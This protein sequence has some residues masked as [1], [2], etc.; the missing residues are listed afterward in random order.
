MKNTKFKDLYLLLIKH[1]KFIVFL[2]VIFVIT[3]IILSFSPKLE[4]FHP[5]KVREFIL[6]YGK[7]A[8][9]VFI[10]LQT[11][12]VIFA[13]IPGQ[14]TGF[15]GGYLFGWK[16]GFLY[17]MIGL[18]VGS[19]IIFILSRKLGRP[20]VQKFNSAEAIHDFEG[21]FIA[22]GSKMDKGISTLKEH[23]LLTFFLIMLL[24]ALP[25]DLVCFVAGLSTIPIYK[26]LT[27][28]LLGRF[29]GML[30]LSLVG[31]G[32]SKDELNIFYVVFI[33]FCII[34]MVF[35]LFNKKSVENYMKR[36]VRKKV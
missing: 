27:A 30:V 28:A 11:L 16:L 5:K 2:L 14:A 8:P 7:F 6:G 18:T 33:V 22:D 4:A 17:S 26:L 32:V 23:S 36:F 24:P 12:Q 31:D 35:Y 3:I 34:L 9:L 29:P 10:I 1:R 20:F 15:A 25:D 21:L 13:P 19:L